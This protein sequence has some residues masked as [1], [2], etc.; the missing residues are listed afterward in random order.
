LKGDGMVPDPREPSRRPPPFS[1]DTIAD[2][3]T[4]EHVSAQMLALHLD[5]TT[6]VSSR[7]FA[8]VDRSAAWIASRFGLAGGKRV[9]DFG[10]GPG[11]YTT[12]F[13]AAG[14]RVT[15]IDFSLRSIRHA[16]ACAHASGLGVDH[17]CADYLDYT[18][19]GRFDLI[20]LIMCDLCALAPGKRRRLLDKFRGCLAPGGAVLLDVYSTL[21][22]A[23][24]VE[25]ASCTSRPEGGFWS[26]GPHRE[27][28]NTF[29]YEDDMVTLDRYTIL[30]E[31]RSRVICNWLQYFSVETL[32]AELAGS[33][34]VLEEI[35]ADVAGADF[36]PAAP[37]FAIVARAT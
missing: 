7:R 20:T 4:D 16:Q 25:S 24:F 11:L 31:G 2:L 35:F 13:A 8:F 19:G 17:V 15:G 33:G 26:A 34:L 6:D 32:R 28:R 36:D 21:A 12:R 10:C 14:A 29:K 1:C 18:P 22:F 37:E 3:W 5:G 9:A 23:A 27:L 30:E